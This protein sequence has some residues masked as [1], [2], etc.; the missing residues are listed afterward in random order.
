MRPCST[1]LS[2][3][4]ALLLAGVPLLLAPTPDGVASAQKEQRKPPS[5]R[6][7]K[8]LGRWAFKRLSEAQ[9]ALQAG[10]YDR[11][12]E[13]LDEMR[14][15]DKLELHERALMH[16]TYAYVY[17]ER[18]DYRS[19]LKS[20]EAAI[21]TGELAPQT[22]LNVRYNVAQMYVA[23]EQYDKGIAAL[24]EWFARAENPQPSAYMLFANAY[25]QKEDYRSA[26]PLAESGLAKAE[27]PQESWLKLVLGLYLHFER[28]EDG[29][30]ILER[31][32]RRFPSKSYLTQL[33]AIYG[34]L[35]REKDA[36]AAYEVAFLKGYLEEER[37]L[38]RM[39]Q[40]YL[41]HDVPYKAAKLMEKGLADKKIKGTADHWELLANAWIRAQ[42]LS[43]SLE[44]LERAAEL[45][46]DGKL[47]LR[48]GQVHLQ[49]ERWAQAASALVKAHQKGGLD[50]P[51]NAH[52][53]LGIARFHS[54]N[55]EAAERSFRNALKF[56]RS[57]RQARQWLNH[58]AQ[59]AA[60]AAES[61]S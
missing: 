42:E 21:A 17:S 57:K 40:L 58:L 44:P 4:L 1:L 8:A 39:A 55:P 5:T 16:Q 37:E 59:E 46:D 36:F 33:S 6:R 47:W 41:Y 14:R 52:L 19:A 56:E 28:Y 20:L 13:L 24:K 38:V 53:L 45:S 23:T 48:L 3:L 54:G 50:K 9:E 11:A 43:R 29:A 27:D 31:L 25:V 51:G 7:A 26:L 18:E 22:E 34:E 49:D 60:A 61:A 32:I 35:G 12:M 15:N 2:G 30:R 10:N